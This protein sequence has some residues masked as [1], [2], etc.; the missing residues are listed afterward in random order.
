MASDEKV[1][2]S[3][4]NAMVAQAVTLYNGM[5]LENF[6]SGSAAYD[7]WI[8][9]FRVRV[10]QK[11]VTLV[12]LAARQ[13]ES[14]GDHEGMLRATQKLIAWNPW[15]E[16]ATRWEMR[17][18]ARQGN[19]GAAL[20]RYEALRDVLGTALDT[21]PGKPL[22]AYAQT[23]RDAAGDRSA[24]VERRRARAAGNLPTSSTP[25]FGRKRELAIVLDKLNDGEQRLI[26]IV[27]L[28]GSG[29]TRLALTCAHAVADHFVDGA[30]F[31]NLA[32]ITA[33][34]HDPAVMRRLI[35]QKIATVFKLSLNPRI[36]VF[37]QLAEYM[38]GRHALLVLDNMEHLLAGGDIVAELLR[39]MPQG[40]IITP[41]TML[42]TLLIRG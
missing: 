36:H 22:Q 28:G 5:L 12:T 7:E 17:A 34:H 32:S 8:E 40:G 41:P 2:D 33:P 16:Q 15:D 38:K 23:L 30:W 42:Q 39:E 31:V 20:A 6:E 29:K 21:E 4:A 18:F 24:P 14:R 1:T 10:H 13:A 27:G 9:E 37:D 19:F 26:T 25:F 3:K 35:L 11:A